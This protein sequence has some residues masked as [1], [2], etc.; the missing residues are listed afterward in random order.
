MR[1]C[2]RVAVAILATTVDS[3]SIPSSILRFGK[4]AILRSRD[5]RAGIVDSP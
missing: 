1:V 5:R 4:G 3:Q 2:E